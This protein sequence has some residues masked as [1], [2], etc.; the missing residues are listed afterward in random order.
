MNWQLQTAKNRLSQVVQEAKRSGPQTI[1][2]HGKP[3]AVVLSAEDYSALTR[4]GSLVGFLRSSP[5][6][7]Q[8]LT[9]ERSDDLGR[10]VR[11]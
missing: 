2:V 6:A 7:E 4:Q 8:E 5:W 9:I 1:T 10:D 11:L 3:A